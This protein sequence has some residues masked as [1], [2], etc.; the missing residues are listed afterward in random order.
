MRIVKQ[1]IRNALAQML[2]TLLTGAVCLLL[3]ACTGTAGELGVTKVLLVYLA[4]D[5]NLSGESHEKLEAIRRGYSSMPDT[6]LLVYQD[7]KDTPPR[8]L[9]ITG[10]QANS[11]IETLEQ[12][13]TENSAH[14]AVF[15]RAIAKAS[16]LYPQAAFNLLVFSHASGWL[17]EGNLTNPQWGLTARSVLTDGNNEMALAD[18]AAAIPNDRFNYIV[19]ETCFMAGVEVAWEL[20]RKA[21]YIAASSAEIVSPGFTNSY[22]QHIGQL[23]SGNP[24]RFMQEAF[25]GFD[26]RSGYMRSA[27]FSIIQTDRLAALAAYIKE[28]CDLSKPVAVNGIQHFDRSGYH[29]FCDFEDY[30]SR[31][32]AAGDKREQLQQLIEACVVWKASTPFFMEGYNGFAIDR[33]SGLTAYIMQERY[34]LLNRSYQSM[35]WYKAIAPESE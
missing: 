34:P 9:E 1:R 10:T 17:P 4:A 14:P 33:H 24:Q 7:A 5:N 29:L 19:F 18:F 8:L 16:V 15:A 31:L 23:V 21:R 13:E 11:T 22:E 28:H 20:R 25:A 26:S 27:T 6:R 30:Y 3:C 35:E 32:P 12:Y 2:Q